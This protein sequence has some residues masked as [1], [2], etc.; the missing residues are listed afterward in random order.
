MRPS[1]AHAGLTSQLGRSPLHG[2]RAALPCP[3]WSLASE[4]AGRSPWSSRASSSLDRRPSAPVRS[5]PPG[6][7]RTVSSTGSDGP[8]SSSPP[9]RRHPARHRRSC[10]RSWTC[11][12]SR[13]TP[14]ARRGHD[15]GTAR[16]ARPGLRGGSNDRGPLGLG[17]GS[18]GGPRVERIEALERAQA[19]DPRRRATGASR[20]GSTDGRCRPVTGFRNH[21]CWVP[22]L[23]PSSGSW[24]LTSDVERPLEAARVAGELDR[25]GVR[26]EF[27]LAGWSTPGRAARTAARRAGASPPR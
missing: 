10:A 17:G 23:A 13:R 16:S 19:I 3:A 27:A 21:R 20:A 6:R 5:L 7:P 1:S 22:R 11:R 14:T 25:R 8:R 12:A 15:P 9:R 18:L 26:E 4:P 2:T 24:S